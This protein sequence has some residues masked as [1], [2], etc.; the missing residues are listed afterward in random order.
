MCETLGFDYT[1]AILFENNNLGEIS[2]VRLFELLTRS[3]VVFQVSFHEHL[4]DRSE[5]AR[6]RRRGLKPSVRD[7]LSVGSVASRH[8]GWI[9]ALTFSVVAWHLAM[10]DGSGG[11]LEAP[12]HSR[13]HSLTRTGGGDGFDS[14]H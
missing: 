10:R 7:T 8:E 12:L 4:R 2:E 11:A 14:A 9:G 6:K 1:R 3:G 5:G 13:T